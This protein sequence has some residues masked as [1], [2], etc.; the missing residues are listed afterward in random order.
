MVKCA[1]ISPILGFMITLCQLVNITEKF[2]FTLQHTL[3]SSHSSMD[4]TTLVLK[5]FKIFK[6]N[7]ICW[8]SLMLMTTL[9]KC[10]EKEELSLW[11]WIT[12]HLNLKC[13]MKLKS[14]KLTTCNTQLTGLEDQLLLAMLNLFIQMILQFID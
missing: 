11:Q 3:H 8:L 6:F 4:L 14:L 13:S 5:K 7:K 2:I 1:H 10:K 12:I 9:G